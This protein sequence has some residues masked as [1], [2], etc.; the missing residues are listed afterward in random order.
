MATPARLDAIDKFRGCA[1][2]LMVLADYLADVNRAP[3]W[4]KHAPD[5]GYTVTDLI[6]PLFVVAIGLTY[7]LSFRRRLAR[8]GARK[9][10]E[11]AIV[12]NL[13]LIGLGFL[14]TVG[15]N[16]LGVYPSTINWGL[17]Q[18]LGA[19]GLLTLLVIRLPA[20]WRAGVGLGLL[21]IYQARL[22]CCWL[23]A[24]RSAPQNGPWGALSWGALL[25][26]ATVLA[27]WYHDPARRWRWA[28]WASLAMLLAGL[29]ASLVIPVSKA[30]ASASYILI[31]LGLSALIFLGFHVL[32]ERGL[33]APLL[34]AW[35][36]NPL[37]LYV[38]HGVLLGVFAL[39][40][41]PGWYV[42]APLWLAG[43][44]ATALVVAL[45]WI[46]WWLDKR[47][48]YIAL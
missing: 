46:A 14:M 22:D 13:A 42:E 27:D 28:P 1:I 45:S 9:T 10:Y 7:G 17:L 16:L 8:D 31:S 29:A 37:L 30:R 48:W 34:S 12:R 43:L 40:P 18:A 2:L 41:I 24:V 38:L 21:A 47:Q 26:L 11:H 15:G 23:D 25:I 5:V 32:G 33:R 44:Q 19:A 6:A 39:P 3:A 20:G 4:L 36:R 35:G